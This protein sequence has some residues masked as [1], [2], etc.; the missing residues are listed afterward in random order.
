MNAADRLEGY[1]PRFSKN[2][3]KS[4]LTD[5]MSFT[6]DYSEAESVVEKDTVIKELDKFVSEL[7]KMLED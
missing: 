7:V 6:D 4:M 1:K 2:E 3:L 5:I